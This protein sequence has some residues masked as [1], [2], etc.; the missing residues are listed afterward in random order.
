M[1]FHTAA[2]NIQTR[3]LKLNPYESLLVLVADY[4][5]VP[6]H[7][8][9]RGGNIVMGTRVACPDTVVFVGT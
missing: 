8:L 5:A 2:D 1:G 6:A 3:K 4:A 9:D 7:K